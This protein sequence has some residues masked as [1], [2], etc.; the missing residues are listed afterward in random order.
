MQHFCLA[1]NRKYYS[2]AFWEIR[3]AWINQNIGWILGSLILIYILWKAVRLIFRKKAEE[4]VMKRKKAGSRLLKDMLFVRNLLRHPID[5]FYDIK[6]GKRGSVLS[7]TII[8]II[9]F[10][11]FLWD[12][13]FR[14]FIFNYSDAK[15]TSLLFIA[16]LFFIPCFLWVT[17]NYLV[18]SINEGEGTYKKVYIGTAYALTPYFLLTPVTLVFTYVLT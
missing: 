14:G 16:A 17:G 18:S 11:V 9:A 8:Y 3:D 7:A 15:N 5:S 4:Q 1:G 6:H 12:R 2:Q 10:L 13:L